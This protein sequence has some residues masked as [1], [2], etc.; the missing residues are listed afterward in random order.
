[1]ADVVGLYRRF[2]VRLPELRDGWVSTRCFAGSHQD[3]HPSARV[4][5]RSG[6]FRCF[7]CGARGGALD[8]L[9]LL[10]VRDRDEAR[11][12]AVD[13]GVLDPPKR[14]RTSVPRPE[15]TPRPAPAA[16]TAPAASVGGRVDYDRLNDAVHDRAWVYV[17]EH[18]RPV[19]RVRRLDLTDGTKRIWQERPAG[20]GWL[21]GLDG[22]ELPLYRLPLVLAAARQHRPVLVVEGEKAVDALDRVGLLATTNAG[23]AGKWRPDHTAA[24]AGATVTVIC[25]S[26]LPG[27][28]HAMDVTVHMVAAGVDAKTPLDLFPLQNDGADLVDYLAGVADTV[29]AVTPGIDA[30]ELRSRL[31]R[32]LER[33]L[34]RCLPANTDDLYRL[35]EHARY[36]NDPDGQ[37]IVA[38]PSCNQER[39]HK[40]SHG[41]AY[42]V[43]G[44]Q[45]PAPA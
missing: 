27:R 21:P 35:A 33:E 26:D 28:L 40:V 31:R 17:D 8:A 10:G 43:C 44:A 6:G 25:D 2:G 13:Y 34:A 16:E 42:C 20:D 14:P 36:L 37:T 23:G 19:G 4:N 3:R 24:L 15:P 1:M 30:D 12:L 18:G 45:Q 32:I 29:H 7:T 39:P 41:V 5:L 11:R 9:Q 38:C 22:G